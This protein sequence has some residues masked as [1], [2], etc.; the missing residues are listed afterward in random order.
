MANLS[1]SEFRSAVSAI[2][3]TLAS[4]LPQP[5]ITNQ[6]VSIGGSSTASA[7]FNSKTYAVRLFTDTACAIKFGDVGS[8]VATTDARMAANTVEYFGVQPGQIVS[9]IT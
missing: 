4:V 5:A 2:G 7:A 6:N 9:V 1:I 8:T 3:S